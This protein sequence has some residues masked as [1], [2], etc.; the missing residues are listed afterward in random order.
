MRNFGMKLWQQLAQHKDQIALVEL[1]AQGQRHEL[2]YSEWLKQVQRVSVGLLELGLEPGQRVGMVA[3]N[4][5]E[6]WTL[7]ISAWVIGA[8]MVPLVP[9]RERKETLRCLARSGT[10]W[11]V[12]RDLEGL[13]HLRGQAGDLPDHLQW[14]VLQDGQVPQAANIHS[15]SK[16]QESGRYR[17]LRGADKT[18]TKRIYDL[19]WEAPALILFEPELSDDPHGAFF[20]A[21][22]LSQQLDQLGGDLMWEHA[23]FASVV[24]YGWFHALYLGLATLLGGHTLLGAPQLGVMLSKLEQLGPTHLLSAP[25]FL[26]GQAKRWQKRLE[27]APE[28][29]KRIVDPEEEAKQGFSFTKALASFSERAAQRALYEPI[30]QDLG[31]K[32]KV[33]YVIDG[34]LPQEVQQILEA[35]RVD[36]LG[37]FGLP[38]CGLS[39]M[40]RP[41]A[42]KRGSV[43]RP[44]QGYACK[45]ERAKEGEPGEIFLRSEVLLSGYWDKKGPRQLQEGWLMTGQRGAIREGYLYLERAAQAQ[46]PTE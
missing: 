30:R 26:E 31:D 46:D 12:V 28:L 14:V 38:E 11:I 40:E 43:G 27:Q 9:G 24:S 44:I 1:D 16:L 4:C 15:L 13:D 42:A 6:W 39:H 23:R 32:L 5:Q 45:I 20:T 7:A 41:G 3:Q 25:S 21:R 34:E 33:I 22:A 29:L 8:C 36:A 35:I 17:L 37:V 2:S 18:W 10:D 19:S